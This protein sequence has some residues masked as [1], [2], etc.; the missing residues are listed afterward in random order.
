MGATASK[1]TE[2]KVF[3]PSTSINVGP[4]LINQLDNSIETDYIR[5]QYTEKYIQEE[6]SK[7]L[8]ALSA[9][10]DA[11]FQNNLKKSL[12]TEDE[13]E[14]VSFSKINAGLIELNEKLTNKESS[15]LKLS[16]GVIAAK[17]EVVKCLQDNKGRPLNCWDE[18]KNFEKFVNELK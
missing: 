9:K 8:D 14:N 2:T 5:S 16:E 7:R 17:Q 15:F 1:P 4:S 10:V 11:E 13:D 18:V 3:T 12:K 6:V